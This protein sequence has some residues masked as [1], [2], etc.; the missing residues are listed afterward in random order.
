MVV[1]YTYPF[2]VFKLVTHFNFYVSDLAKPFL[3]LPD[4][5]T[6]KPPFSLL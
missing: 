1:W 4:N 3:R 5:Q 2:F 6:T